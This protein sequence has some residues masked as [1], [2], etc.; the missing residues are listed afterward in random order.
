MAQKPSL[1]NLLSSVT[2]PPLPQKVPLPNFNLIQTAQ[3]TD[4][5]KEETEDPDN[6]EKE[7]EKE[8]PEETEAQNDA[9]QSPGGSK[10]SL[11]SS[12]SLPNLPSAHLPH[13]ASPNLTFP[14]TGL[15]YAPVS[16]SSEL[17]DDLTTGRPGFP[18][19]PKLPGFPTMPPALNVPL[20]TGQSL[21]QLF[22]GWFG[23][24]RK[25]NHLTRESDEDLITK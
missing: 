15:F 19:F 25:P 18:N 10:P 5:G 1:W 9:T 24:A 7:K 23:Q 17:D 4:K 21:A 22:Q 6:E 13:F 12:L 20:P 16:P 11:L 8:E 14:W 3:E 2:L